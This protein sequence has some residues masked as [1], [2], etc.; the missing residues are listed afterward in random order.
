MLS[1]CNFFF[2]ICPQPKPA[3]ILL[4]LIHPGHLAV[5]PPIN[6]HTE[7][8]IQV[9]PLPKL[10]ALSHFYFHTQYQEIYGLAPAQISF[11]RVMA[12]VNASVSVSIPLKVICLCS[13]HVPEPRQVL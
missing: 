13:Y 2:S 1:L 3:S 10:E 12:L 7:S 5:S 4:H 11:T 6:V 8:I 9:Q